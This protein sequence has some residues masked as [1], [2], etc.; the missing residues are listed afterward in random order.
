MRLLVSVRSADE[1]PAA[2]AGGAEIVDAKEPAR[3]ALGAV[4][5]GEL[6]EISRV[7]PAGWPLSVALGD[8]ADDRELASAWRLLDAINGERPLFVK[9]GLSAARD[10]AGARSI[11]RHAVTLAASSPSGPG[12]VAVA[13]GDAEGPP[14]GAVV[15]LASEA[16]A[17]GVL[18][19]TWRKDGRDLFSFMAEPT[20]RAWATSARACGLLVAAAGSLSA[21][22]IQRAA[23]LPLD[24]VGVRGAACLGGRN[25][26]VDQ[27]LV[28]ALAAAI[29][30]SRAQPHAVA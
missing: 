2:V 19:D 29:P 18:L 20:V 4:G 24:V 21:A 22:G 10:L 14:P 13:Y 9:V 7:L 16:G 3:G 1:V 5:P 11:L 17:R 23:T 27:A 30:G 6:R 15:E 12:V 26:R 28:R 25:G 8:P